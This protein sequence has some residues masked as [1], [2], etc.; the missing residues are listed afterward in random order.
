MDLLCLSR[1]GEQDHDVP[2]YKVTS[3][4][5]FNPVTK[6]TQATVLNLETKEV[7]KVAKGA[8]QVLIKLSNAGDEASDAVRITAALVALIFLLNPPFRI[9]G[10]HFCASWFESSRCCSYCPR[11]EWREWN[12]LD[13]A[14]S[15]NDF[16]LGSS[17]P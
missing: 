10:Y 16:S 7:F 8:P 12:S 6:M 9:L 3:F 1:L 15:W 13:L 11:T 17:A 5:P 4:T 14:F 2:G